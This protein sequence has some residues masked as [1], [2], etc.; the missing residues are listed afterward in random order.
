M[1]GSPPTPLGSAPRGTSHGSNARSSTCPATSGAGE[2]FTDLVDAQARVSAWCSQWAG[3]RFHGTTVARPVEMFTQVEASCLLPVPAAYDVPVFTS[4]KVHRDFHVEVAKSLYSLPAQW[5]GQHL[6]APADGELVKLFAG[7]QLVRT[8]PRQRPSGRSTD[9]TD[10]LVELV[11]Y[12]MRD[13][14]ALIAVC[15]G[16]GP[17]I[18]IYAE[19]L[20]DDPLPWTRMRTV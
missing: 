17:N 4:V 10:L 15:A 1:P 6:D 5:I 16:H 13:L 19:R 18:G 3:M 14:S 8:H 11:G 20:L 7:G 12:A 2:T 9:R